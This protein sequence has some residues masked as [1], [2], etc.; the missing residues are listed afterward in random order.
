MS[1]LKV[2]ADDQILWLGKLCRICLVLLHGVTL[3][4]LKSVVSF[5]FRRKHLTAL[6]LFISS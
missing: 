4:E 6:K 2:N 1:S 3:P 5:E